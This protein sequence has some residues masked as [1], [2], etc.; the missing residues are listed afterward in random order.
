[1]NRVSIVTVLSLLLAVGVSLAWPQARRPDRLSIVRADQH[2]KLGFNIGAIA[3][4]TALII[5]YAH[6]W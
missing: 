6:W 1:M 4:L 2:T 3:V 5:F